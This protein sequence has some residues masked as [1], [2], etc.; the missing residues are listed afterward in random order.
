[1]NIHLCIVTGQPLANLV[2]LLQERPEKVVLL[3]SNAM[4]DAAA[5]FRRALAD[6]GWADAA[7][8]S[9]E[10]LPDNGYDNLRLFALEVEERLLNKHPESCIH[11]N[12]TGGNKLMALAFFDVFN[13]APHRIYYTDTKNQSLEQLHPL[14]TPHLKMESVLSLKIA[15]KVAGKTLRSR[16]DDDMEWQVRAKQRKPLTRL[17][18]ESAEDMQGLISL[19]NRQ[20]TAK[21][22]ANPALILSRAPQGLYFKALE[23]ACSLGLLDSDPTDKCRYQP[24]NKDAYRYFTGGWLEEFVWHCARDQG[25]DDVAVNIVFTDDIKR[26]ADIRNEL[27][28]AVLHQNRL[29]LIE[30]KSGQ[31][32][33]DDQN[34]ADIIYKLDSLASNAAGVLG[35]RLLV[36]AQALKHDT[37]KGRTVDTR[38]RAESHAIHTCEVEQLR[39]LKD[40]LRGWVDTGTWPT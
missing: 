13:H 33:S 23:M 9:I 29:L 16:Q 40:W 5:A 19:F 39:L 3:I 35:D 36:S 12:I 30:C 27:D 28:I 22:P 26:S 7:I 24:I 18:A 2:A 32:G 1:L 34:D 4:S 8:D 10:G 21:Q 6:A 31:L 11:L 38:A 15:L 20:L 17:L 14:G 25:A 37:R